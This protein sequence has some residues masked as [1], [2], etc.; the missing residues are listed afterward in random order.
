MQGTIDERTA[1]L[2]R[3]ILS[4]IRITWETALLAVILIL[5]FATRFY[6]LESRVMSHDETIHVYHNSW[7]LFTGQGYRHDPLSHGPFQTHVVALSYFLFG[8]SDTTARIPAVLFS[9]ATVGIVWLYRRYLGKAGTIIA[10]IL[11]LISPYMLYYGRYVRN[12]AYA[13]FAGVALLWAILRYLETGKDKYTYWVTFATVLHFTAKETSFIYTAQVLSFLGFYFLYQIAR[14]TWPKAS[15]RNPFLILFLAAMLMLGLSGF[16]TLRERQAAGPSATDTAVPAV[17]GQA[18]PGLP[19][20]GPSPIVLAL[21]ILG[22]LAMLVALYF[23]I[24]GMTWQKLR[25]ERSF[26][27]MIVI[28]TLV[29]PQLSAFG[30]YFMGWNVPTNATEVTNLNITDIGRIAVFLIPFFIASVAIGLFWKPKTWLINAAIY[31][32]FFTIFYTTVFTNGAGFFTGTVGSLGYWLKQQGVER[33]SQPWYYY[34]FVQVPIYEYLPALA[35]LLAYGLLIFGKRPLLRFTQAFQQL[36]A[37]ITS[38]EDSIETAQ[39]GSE[40]RE[41]AEPVLQPAP[42][43]PLLAFYVAASF[44]SFS[45]AGEKMP[46]LTVHMTWP[47]VLF[48]GWAL[49]YLV[50]TVIWERFKVWRGWL[51]LLV[52]V[53]FIISFLAAAGS[54]FGATPPFQ[55]QSLDNLQAT[56]TFVT[57]FVIAAISA[58]LL[59]KLAAAWP[60]EQFVRVVSLL[61]FA[62]L[63]VLT[64]RTAIQSSY[65]NY[66]N[67]NELLV[68]AH[69]AGGVK[70]VM[71]QV[72]QISRRTTDGL[73]IPVAY[74]G[75]YPFFWY[76]R[77]Y[78]NAQY[79][80]SNPSRTLREVP[81]IIVG[82]TNFGKIEPVVGDAYEK[83]EYIR[84]WW[85]NQDYFNLS[86]SRI[87]GAIRN[88]QMRA[89]LFDIWLNRD[90]TQYGQVTGRDMSLENW[91]PSTRMRLYVRKDIASK[92]WEYGSASVAAPVAADPYEGK[93]VKLI[94]DNILGAPGTAPGQLQQPR[95]LAVAQDGSLYVADTKNHRIQHIAPD[96]TALHTWGSFADSA[97]GEAPGGTFYEPWGIGLGLDGSVYVADTWNHR[98]QKFTHEGEFIKSWGYFGQAEQPDAFWGPRDIAIDGQGRV[99]VSD[100]GNKRI[101]VFDSDGNFLTQFGVAGLALGEFDEPVGITIGADGKVYVADTWN[102][103]IQVFQEGD[104]GFQVL[105]SW[106][107][108]AW[109]G[110]SLDNKPFLAIDEADNLFV[111]DPEGYRVLQFKDSGEFIRYWGDFGT[112][113]D[114]FG[115]VGSV[116]VDP[117]GGV[118]VSDAGNSRLMHFVIPS[119]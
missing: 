1:W 10:M 38:Q 28:G 46:W 57:A 76:L 33:G 19:S 106:D 12:E 91:S 109:Y 93:G 112:G 63:A 18:L 95:D 40:L 31:Y 26:G 71:D 68:Y 24:R 59:W 111:V 87:W 43:L 64:A 47:M 37:S 94:A 39:E 48:G 15:H 80:G 100:T 69:S 23:L 4:S 25:E 72:E 104:G 119:D 113:P 17:P 89:A 78:T 90:Y 66:D 3:P 45:V 2:D 79:F 108:S 52:L 30:V 32:S 116:A 102:Q 6:D 54:L 103:R 51:M 8:D 11:M 110:Q 83:F 86:L 27:L 9:I 53:I 62:F 42:V 107:V 22:G 5:A 34:A 118:W 81:I 114:A 65:I 35:S 13:A 74:D 115:L 75:E 105:T 70:V 97:A 85:P 20:E 73:A 56:S 88:P 92:I 7:S 29:L 41:P 60:F 84:L 21:G 98:V 67:A 99:F 55:G 36:Q 16:I 58:F 49:G 77:N 61:I 82:D 14:Q 96:G 44:L 50:D 117:D 101:A